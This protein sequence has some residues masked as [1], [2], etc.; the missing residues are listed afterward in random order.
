MKVGDPKARDF[1]MEECSKSNWSTRQLE[2][3]INT[4]SYQRLLM[5]QWRHEIKV[6]DLIDV[7]ACEPII[8]KRTGKCPKEDSRY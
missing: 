7:S 6:L 5:S 1:Y 8:L 4:F 3:Q 2:R